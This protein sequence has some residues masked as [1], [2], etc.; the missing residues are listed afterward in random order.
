[1]L[2]IGVIGTGYVGLTT[3]IGLA[4]FGSTVMCL[5]INN[6]KIQQLNLGALP[7]YE[8]GMDELLRDNVKA[9]RLTFSTD[10]TFGIQWAQIIFIAVGTPQAENGKAD[11]SAVEKTAELIG[12]SLNGYKIVVTKSTVPVGTNEMIRAIIDS[13]N[14]NEYEFDVVSNPEFLREGKAVYDFLHPDRVVIGVSHPRPLDM[15][16]QVYRPLYLNEVPFIITDLRT[17]ELIKYASNSFL[18]MKVAFINE[19]ARLCDT[20]G[21]NVQQL[22]IALG[23]DGRIGSKFLHPGPGFGGSCFPKDTAALTVFAREKG[24][25]LGLV[26]E[27]IAS[28]SRQKEFIVHK[29][30]GRMGA[31]SGRRFGI[32]GLAFKSETDDMRESAAITIIDQL[33]REG[34]M[35]RA[36]DPRAMENAKKIWDNHQIS[37][38]RDEYDTV[39]DADAVVILTEWNQFRNL[40]IPRIKSAMRESYFFDFRNIYRRKQMEEYGLIY[41]CIGR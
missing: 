15:L 29:I 13:F 5:D 11:L 36:Y 37:F 31:V 28:N 19:M 2:K 3:G 6:E 25:P 1:M 18:A 34:A 22:A 23:K 35:I 27:T 24:M 9:G 40:D 16:K 17:S 38:G 33:L 26:E 21:A 14:A 30:K 7:I 8:P 12:K 41:E 10:L 39:Q 4:N 32:L 20:V